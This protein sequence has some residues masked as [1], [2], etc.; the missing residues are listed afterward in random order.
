M[1]E[2]HRVRRI[3]MCAQTASSV[4]PRKISSSAKAMH[5]TGI[6][7]KIRSFFILSFSGSDPSDMCPFSIEEENPRFFTDVSVDEVVV[8]AEIK[9]EVRKG[10]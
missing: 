1:L 7:V 9:N 4:L 8:K 5:I 2:R 10:R 6:A 3:P